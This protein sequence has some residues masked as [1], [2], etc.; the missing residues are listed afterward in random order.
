MRSH[1]IEAWALKLVDQVKNGQ[2]IED[3]RVELKADW[4][5]ARKAAR[6][7]AGHANAARGVSILWLI[8]LDEKRGV[9]GVQHGDLADWYAQVK[10]QFNELAPF[11]TDINVPVAGNVIVALLFETDRAPFVV[12]NPD[13]SG[14]ISREVPWREGTAIDSATREQLIRLLSPLRSQLAFEVL[15]GGLTCRAYEQ[16]E[17]DLWNLDVDLYVET[18]VGQAIVIPFHRCGVSITIQSNGDTITFQKIAL[19]PPIRYGSRGSSVQS[20]TIESTSDEALLYGPGRLILLGEAVVS[21][22]DAPAIQVADDV[23]HVSM[24]VSLLPVYAEQASI[25]RAELVPTAPEHGE[26]Y[27]WTFPTT[28]PSP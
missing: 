15:K 13:G 3:A 4:P 25:I 28:Q 12:K 22:N 18:E 26:R 9:I 19:G 2:P 10:S 23:S 1:E 7:I 20:K 5:D 11:M 16:T 21:F 8:G 17:S 27:R 6:R 14:S 24:R